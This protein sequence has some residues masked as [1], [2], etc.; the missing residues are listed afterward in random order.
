M[1]VWQIKYKLNKCNATTYVSP[2]YKTLK[3]NEWINDHQLTHLTH[4]HTHYK[5][6]RKP[7]H[8]MIPQPKG[9]EKKWRLNNEEEERDQIKYKQFD[10]N[11]N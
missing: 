7:N 1:C 2:L 5:L 9:T 10:F 6:K 3:F 8:L 11:Q 4:T